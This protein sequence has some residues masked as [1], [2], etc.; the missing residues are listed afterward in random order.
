MNMHFHSIPCDGNQLQFAETM[1]KSASP[2]LQQL[3]Y[4]YNWSSF[5]I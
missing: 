3:L 4:A 5:G 2:F 1:F